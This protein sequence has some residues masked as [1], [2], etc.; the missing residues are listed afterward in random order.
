MRISPHDSVIRFSYEVTSYEG[1]DLKAATTGNEASNMWLCFQLD[2]S[3]NEEFIG[4]RFLIQ[5]M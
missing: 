5:L 1:R 3:S 2:I 4:I